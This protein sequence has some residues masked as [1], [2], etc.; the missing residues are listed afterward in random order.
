MIAYN[1]QSLD[2]L[3]LQ[4]QAREGFER[5]LIPREEY[6]RIRTT[7]PYRFYQPDL[8]IRIGLFAL[9]AIAAACGLGIFLL[10]TIGGGE[11]ALSMV[12][13]FYAG[14]AIIVLELFIHQ[15]R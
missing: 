8:S 11:R 5:N 6:D 14:I 13:L 12:I 3:D 1:R 7:Y 4:Q 2:N 10:G 9:T 15:K